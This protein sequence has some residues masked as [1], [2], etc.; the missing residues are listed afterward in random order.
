MK[1]NK[2]QKHAPDM[3]LKL[4]I[5]LQDIGEPYRSTTGQID[6]PFSTKS[7][8]EAIRGGELKKLLEQAAVLIDAEV[9]QFTAARGKR[10]AKKG[11]A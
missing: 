9:A 4:T 3:R 11:H 7:I 8:T 1:R 5:T 10:H 6:W 2:L